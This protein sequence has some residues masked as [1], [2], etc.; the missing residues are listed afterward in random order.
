MEGY[1]P[2]DSSHFTTGDVI[3]KA[4]LDRNVFHSG[5]VLGVL[6]HN[7]QGASVVFVDKNGQVLLVE[8]WCHL[9]RTEGCA[10]AGRNLES[11]CRSVRID[12]A[13]YSALQVES[14]TLD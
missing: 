5:A 9:I 8:H 1:I 7:L 3:A 11:S 13:M 14:A 6:V 12:K 4:P 2:L 10:V